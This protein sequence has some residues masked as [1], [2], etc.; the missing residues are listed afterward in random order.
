MSDEP[1]YHGLRVGRAT[2]TVEVAD[3]SDET[4]TIEE[5]TVDYEPIHKDDEWL[6]E[7]DSWVAH[8]ADENG[9]IGL[10]AGV[11][12]PYERLGILEL[13]E[14]MTREESLDWLTDEEERW[15]QF[16]DETIESDVTA[17]DLLEGSVR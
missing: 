10:T 12:L 7:E 16:L 8:F 11:H 1:L 2:R 4:Q 5:G 3:P 14:P 15:Q 9:E 17:A 13:P 6:W